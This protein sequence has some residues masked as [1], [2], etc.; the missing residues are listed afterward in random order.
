MFL[1]VIL[2]IWV[3]WSKIFQKKGSAYPYPSLF[4]GL[5]QMC[6]GG[7][8]PTVTVFAKG[9]LQKLYCSLNGVDGEFGSSAAQILLGDGGDQPFVDLCSSLSSR[10]LW[11]FLFLFGWEKGLLR[12]SCPR[13]ECIRWCQQ[14][15]SHRRSV[16]I[17]RKHST[18]FDRLHWNGLC[19]VF[20][21]VEGSCNC[22]W[23]EMKL[24]ADVI[25]RRLVRKHSKTGDRL[26]V[27]NFNLFTVLK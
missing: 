5:M 14:R 15:Q 16:Y 27:K 7:L 18:I 24:W 20:W 2:S 22:F 3:R 25:V 19:Q 23:L 10:G 4:Y 26:N 12:G 17:V 11:V 6:P 1:I 13:V 8:Q 9:A 21:E